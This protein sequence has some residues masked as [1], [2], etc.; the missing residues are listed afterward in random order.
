M[1]YNFSIPLF[2]LLIWIILAIFAPVLPFNPDQ[3]FLNKIL[4]PPNWEQWLGYDDLGR[5]ISSRLIMGARTSLS[6]AIVVVTISFL[7]GTFLGLISAWLGGFWDKCLVMI[8]DLFIAFPGIL[9]A[10][11]LAGL[12]GPGLTNAVI[13]LSIVS[14]VG[15]ARLARV[16]TLSKKK[17][18]HIDA[19]RALGTQ[20]FLI[21]QKH[22]LPLIMTPLTIEATFSFAGVVIAEAGLSFLGLGVQPPVASWGS[23]IR[24]GGQYMLVAPHMVLAPGFAIL[25][26]VL[27]INLLGDRLRDKMDIKEINKN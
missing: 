27:C 17:Y 8:I 23:M 18:V 7:V 16:Q 20:N 25:S 12:L 3:I 4:L 21:A 9:L 15:F 26:L 19:A 10:I 13:A 24:D 6:V 14:W 5:S 2:I 22:I 1:K 11:A